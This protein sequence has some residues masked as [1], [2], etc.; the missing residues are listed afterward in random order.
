VVSALDN[1]AAGGALRASAEIRFCWLP[2]SRCA[3]L[4]DV[5]WNWRGVATN[6]RSSGLT[7]AG[8]GMKGIV[9]SAAGPCSLLL[10]GNLLYDS[11]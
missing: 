5:I 2:R 3:R 10:A 11:G 6:A 9:A 7:E 4:I 1:A 8:M